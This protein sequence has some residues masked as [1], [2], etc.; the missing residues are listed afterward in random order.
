MKYNYIIAIDGPAGS[1][2]STIARL[3]AKML[4]ILYIDSG[5]MYRAMTLYMIENH[6]LNTTQKLLQKH[7]NKIKIT[8]INKKNK[9]LI[10]LNNKNVTNEIRSSKVTMCVSKVSAIGVVR[11]EL[12]KRQ[13]KLGQHNSI[14]MDGRDIG[15]T[16]FKNAN[17]KI[18]LTA[19]AYIRAK[20]RKLDL[21]KISE[22][23]NIKDLVTQI[24]NRDNYDSSRAISP[25]SKAQDAIVIDSSNLSIEEVLEKIIF[26]LPTTDSMSI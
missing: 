21:K 10:F 7:L 6:L 23:A 14:I 12:V 15:T 5:A 4:G 18:Y 26:F 13:K 1:G 17:L 24:Q 9:Q 16:V 19:S 20:R 3:V 25:L 8:F 22:K 2:K 11:K